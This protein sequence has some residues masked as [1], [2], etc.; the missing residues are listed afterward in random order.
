M[1]NALSNFVNGAQGPIALFP[2]GVIEDSS[3]NTLVVSENGGIG[4]VGIMVSVD[5]NTGIR[6]SITELGD[7]TQ[8][9]IGRTGIDLA[10]EN[11][12][13][14]LFLDANGGASRRGLLHRVLPDGSRI[15][16]SD[17]NNPGQ[18]PVGIDPFGVDVFLIL[19]SDGDGVNDNDDN[20]P[21]D[22]NPGQED[23]DGDGTGD[24]CDSETDDPT[25][26]ADNQIDVLSA[27][28]THDGSNIEC[29]L[30]I[31]SGTDGLR[32]NSTFQCKIDFDD[33]EDEADI[34]CDANGNGIVGGETFNIGNENNDVCTT[35]DLT[36]SY[37]VGKRG[38]SCTGLPSIACS[39]EEVDGDGDTDNTCD[40]KVGGDDAV[41]C[42]VI[43]T[44]DLNDIADVRDVECPSS[45]DCLTDVE[46]NG[47]YD[48]YMFFT[49]KRKND[50]DRV[51]DTDDN[52]KP[53]ET[54][55]VVH[56]RL[57]DPTP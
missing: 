4:N 2:E 53:N 34:G 17:F 40:G 7:I 18:G 6:T 50:R 37:R 54:C 38:G 52:R 32:N 26:D 9:P 30:N 48:T 47:D 31:N 46:M 1:S 35:S 39:V 51:L 45:G 43:M 23:G 55:E 10:L 49:S 12:G 56:V 21:D 16:L 27:E 36:L 13:N 5:L 24:I 11:T 25:G 14:I 20:C 3:G 15:V 33:L 41:I 44:G 8:G 42:R 19:D 57:N 28:A 29:V 22:P